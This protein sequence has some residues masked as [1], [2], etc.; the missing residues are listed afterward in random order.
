M[1]RVLLIN[2]DIQYAAHLEMAL[3]K[4]GFDIETISNEFNLSEKLLTFNPDFIIAKGSSN[5]VS[6]LSV[7]KKLKES[8]KFQG[9]LV[10][11]FSESQR[12]PPEELIKLR[13]DLLLFEPIS[14]LRLVCQLVS[15]TKLD[16]DAV[17]D[18]LFR[19][20]HT[21][22]QFK[23]FE[24]QHLA[25]FDLTID[26]EIQLITHEFIKDD[27]K[28]VIDE[29][30]LRT[31]V[32]PNEDPNNVSIPSE[33]ELVVSD[34]YKDKLQQEL[35]ASSGELPL[36]IETYN[37]TINTIDQDLKKGLSK[38]QTRS[39][40][41]EIFS[42]TPLKEVQEQDEERKKFVRALLKNK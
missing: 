3:R 29:R 11:V 32:N 18:K 12:P 40:N 19:F 28:I 7:G 42:K 33:E 38:R 6:T 41:K 30:D 2:D 31:F 1:D 36:R 34:A 26:S 15:L 37:R 4:V 8:S 21:D 23:N 22:Q 39:S 20:A 14:T 35:K 10:L 13:M 25:T 16:K 24:Q 17:I 9:K 27:D 5:R